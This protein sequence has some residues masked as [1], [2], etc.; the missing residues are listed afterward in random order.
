MNPASPVKVVAASV[1]TAA[2]VASAAMRPLKAK[3]RL[4]A[5]KALP[6]KAWR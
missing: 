1:A 2:H 3:Q 6:P 4:T 5:H